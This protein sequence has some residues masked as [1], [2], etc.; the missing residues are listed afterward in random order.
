MWR[1]VGWRRTG[2]Y[3]EVCRVEE[4]RRICGGLL[5]GGEQEDMWR[6]VGWSRT[7][8]YVEVCR[9]EEDRRICGG[10]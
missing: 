4:N 7:G 8:G 9:V 6:S 2:G 5:G 3:V 1:S 10:L